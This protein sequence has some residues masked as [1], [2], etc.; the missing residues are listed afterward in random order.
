MTQLDNPIAFALTI[1]VIG[2]TPKVEI[3]E[4]EFRELGTSLEKIDTYLLIEESWDALV[5][6][7]RALELAQSEMAI[8]SVMMGGGNDIHDF[9]NAR[10]TCT[11]LVDNLLT[12]TRAFLDKTPGRVRLLF[13]RS[14]QQNFRSATHTAHDTYAGYKFMDNL[15]NYAQHNGSSIDG[16]AYGVRRSEE[17]DAL[18]LIHSAQIK[19]NRCALDR[20]FKVQAREVLDRVSDKNGQI[21]VIPLVREYVQGL[22]DVMQAV[23]SSANEPLENWLQT[24]E[25]ALA[26]LESAGAPKYGQVAVRYSDRGTFAEKVNLHPAA[27]AR[28]DRLRKRN[29]SLSHL[30]RSQRIA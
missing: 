14:A 27:R 18:T 25:R 10:R 21:D 24:N 9:D 28:F 1:A 6:N 2:P 23:R 29:R 12:T 16:V 26:K 13:G 20:A 4:A 22:G 7:Y 30:T 5:A 19:V 11:R 15:R 8:D 3:T 17:G